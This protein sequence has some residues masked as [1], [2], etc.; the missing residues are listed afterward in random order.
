MSARRILHVIHGLT[1]GGAEVDLVRKTAWMVSNGECDATICCLMRRGALADA[2]E[3]KALAA[4]AGKKE[5]G[6]K[7][8]KAMMAYHVAMA[9]C[10]DLLSRVQQ[11]PRFQE[12]QPKKRLL[13]SAL[14]SRP[15]RG[16]VCQSETCASVYKSGLP[17]IDTPYSG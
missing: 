12:S 1:I 16:V 8:R 2:A 7:K 6:E 13:R 11:Q 9:R 15:A 10:S 4:L 5:L 17:I 14:G 3:A